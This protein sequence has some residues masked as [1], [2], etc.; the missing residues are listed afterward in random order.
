L[1]YCAGAPA[2]AE[3]C[4]MKYQFSLIAKRYQA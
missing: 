2:E 4:V 1:K 3:S